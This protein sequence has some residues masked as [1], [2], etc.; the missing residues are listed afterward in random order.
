M[1]EITRAKAIKIY[2]NICDHYSIV[3][4]RFF[5]Y[6]EYKYGDN[7]LFGELVKKGKEELNAGLYDNHHAQWLTQL[8]KNSEKDWAI[9][10]KLAHSK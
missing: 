1:S 10:R 3:R 8:I 4:P 5:H 7:T 6:F 2:N 9:I